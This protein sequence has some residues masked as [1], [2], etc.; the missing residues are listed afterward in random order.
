MNVMNVVV[1]TPKRMSQMPSKSIPSCGGTFM[2]G[3]R[4]EGRGASPTGWHALTSAKNMPGAGLGH[5]EVNATEGPIAALA[6]SSTIL[7][8]ALSTG[9]FGARL[10]PPGSGTN[11][12]KG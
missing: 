12:T 2:T 10:T 5:G 6:N 8:Q 4:V 3:L 7:G 11:P 9:Q 1:S